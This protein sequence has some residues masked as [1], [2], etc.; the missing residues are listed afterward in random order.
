MDS[1]IHELRCDFEL[2]PDCVEGRKRFDIRKNDRGFRVGDV[3]KMLQTNRHDRDSYTGHHAFFS[4]DYI[5]QD[6]NYGLKDGYCVMGITMLSNNGY[7][8]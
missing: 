3:L 1:K 2:F 8:Y 4:V 7:T 6:S 5:I